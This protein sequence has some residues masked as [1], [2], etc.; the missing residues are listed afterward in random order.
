MGLLGQGCLRRE[1]GCRS[2]LVSQEGVAGTRP[3]CPRSGA[4]AGLQ[5][6]FRLVCHSAADSG[7]G[8]KTESGGLS[9][10]GRRHHCRG[11]HGDRRVTGQGVCPR[12]THSVHGHPLSPHRH[13][14]QTKD[15]AGPLGAGLPFSLGLS[16]RLHTTCLRVDLH[17]WPG[18]SLLPG[19]TPPTT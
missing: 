12:H 15:Q 13:D 7:G 8:V 17:P 9:P 14:V 16:R 3:S 4:E 6:P 5:Y 10:H 2:L 11:H 19:L 1:L 18:P